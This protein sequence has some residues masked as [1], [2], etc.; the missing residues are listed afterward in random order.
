[1][2]DERFEQESSGQNFTSPS[3]PPPPP[4][5]APSILKRIINIVV[6]IIGFLIIVGAIV[7]IG[8][9]C[10]SSDNTGE[11]SS[12]TTTVQKSSEAESPP[13]NPSRLLVFT[14]LKYTFYN[15]TLK[16]WTDWPE[17]WKYLDKQVK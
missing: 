12:D 6:N 8:K 1:M 9:G 5:P 11:V 17:D 16:V 13:Q 14:R 7:R 3:S 4:T 2:Y 10:G 15:K